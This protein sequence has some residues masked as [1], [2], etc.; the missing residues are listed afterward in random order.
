MLGSLVLN[1]VGLVENYCNFGFYSKNFVYS[2]ISEISERQL[3]LSIFH[4][5][6]FVKKKTRIF[7]KHLIGTKFI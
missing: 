3:K 6:I 4:L 2:H 7:Y 1:N 5:T